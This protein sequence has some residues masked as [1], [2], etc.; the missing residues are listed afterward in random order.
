MYFM[1]KKIGLIGYGELG[2][3][4]QHLIQQSDNNAHFYYFDDVAFKNGVK[5][6]FPF[7]SYSDD[8]FSDLEF[9]VGLGYKNLVKKGEIIEDLIRNKR[10]LFTFIHPTA[11]VDNTSKI[12]MGTVIY[13]NVTIDK[14]VHI[15]NGCVLNLSVT[16]AHDTKIGDC[17]FLAPSV[18]IS[19]FVKVCKFVFIGTGVC[20][21]NK[22]LIDDYAMV[23]IG[24]V[25]TKNIEKNQIVIGN[26]QKVVN[27]F[28]LL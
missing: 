4:F 2:Q 27:K 28:I 17:S 23:G 20:V 18:T 24:S 1:M 25:I 14:N 3:Q 12:D 21:T 9:L 7:K 16:I 26:P 19:S 15:G 6:V 5:N 11:F 13:P 10:S 8:Q 22:V